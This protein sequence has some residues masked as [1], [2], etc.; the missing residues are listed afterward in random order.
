MVIGGCDRSASNPGHFNPRK[1]AL[2][3]LMNKRLSGTQNWSGDFGEEKHFCPHHKSNH[4]SPP[5]QFTV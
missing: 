1:T 3:Y 2:H 5:N 4:H